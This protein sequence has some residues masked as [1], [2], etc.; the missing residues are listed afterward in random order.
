GAELVTLLGAGIGTAEILAALRGDD[1]V[2]PVLAAHLAVP[3]GRFPRLPS[4]RPGNPRLAVRRRLP[5]LT[6]AA[7]L[8][9]LGRGDAQWLGELADTLHP[10]PE[11]LG[12]RHARMIAVGRETGVRP[13]VGARGPGGGGEGGGA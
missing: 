6:R 7:G 8:A 5:G 9:P 1:A 11:W 12:H 13:V 2:D 10:G 4:L 3:V